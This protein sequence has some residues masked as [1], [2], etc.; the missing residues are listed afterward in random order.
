MDRRPAQRKWVQIALVIL[1]FGLFAGM[2]WYYFQQYDRFNREN[3]EAFIRGFGAWAPLAYA[4]IYIISSP[5]P[6][7]APVI[8][9]VAGL[10]FGTLRGTLLVLGVA[11]TS[12][13]VPF[14]LSRQLGRDWVESKVKGRKLEE[15]YRQ[16]EGGKGFTFIVLLRLVPVL[17]WE[18]QNYVA[19][20]TKVKVPTFI[21]GTV[22][23]IIPG[24]FS[25]VFLGA[26]ATDPTSW[27][28]FA[29]VG[30]K[31][32]TALIPVVVTFIRSRRAK[33]SGAEL[34]L[35]LPEKEGAE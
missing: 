19:G 2:T 12:A 29:A 14:T 4:A 15:V 32:A 27:E 13:L 31:I 33:G 17:P 8:S 6:F 28:F 25:L 23:G 22:L 5:V 30:L 18:V 34:D 11:T 10:L 3:L 7:L 20:L 16:S 9:A 24:S 26:A 35:P 1:I 21:G